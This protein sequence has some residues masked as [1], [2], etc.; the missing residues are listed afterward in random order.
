MQG[1]GRHHQPV[2]GCAYHLG[3]CVQVPMHMRRHM[4]AVLLH[5]AVLPRARFVP[6]RQV[7][8]WTGMPGVI[9]VSNIVG[10][11]EM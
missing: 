2:T 8:P 1:G 10:G 4:H 9:A 6:R 5:V 3:T 7:A 11:C